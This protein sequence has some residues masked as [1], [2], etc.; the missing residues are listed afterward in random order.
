MTDEANVK[1]LENGWSLVEY[2]CWSVSVG[3][4]GLLMLPRHL[5]PEEV[6]DFVGACLAAAEVGARVRQAN[7]R[8]AESDNRSLPESVIQV[9]DTGSTPAGAVRLKGTAGPRTPQASISRRA[10]P[11]RQGL[12]EAD[13]GAPAPHRATEQ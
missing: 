11:S 8:L 2:G 3:P 9:T 5:V 10:Q 7:A 13:I 1:T 6:N 12:R 4:D